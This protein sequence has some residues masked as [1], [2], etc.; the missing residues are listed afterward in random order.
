MPNKNFLG[1]VRYSISPVQVYVKRHRST[2]Y[3]SSSSNNTARQH[4]Q[5]AVHYDHHRQGTD[6]ILGRF[7]LPNDKYHIY[8]TLSIPSVQCSSIRSSNIVYR[9]L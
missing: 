8:S 3:Y 2:W 7:K 9:A 6:L 4:I 1:G 5:L